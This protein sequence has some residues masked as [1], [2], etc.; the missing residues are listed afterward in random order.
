[1][2][3]GLMVILIEFPRFVSVT[4]FQNRCSL[5]RESS[6]FMAVPGRFIGQYPVRPESS[7]L[8]VVAG[9]VLVQKFGTDVG[10]RYKCWI[11]SPVHGI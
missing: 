10:V 8:A 1:M 6:L 5:P 2:S 11:R 3:S 7:L 4:A 9:N